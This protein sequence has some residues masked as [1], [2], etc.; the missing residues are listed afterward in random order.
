MSFEIPWSYGEDEIREKQEADAR[1]AEA[2]WQ[3]EE[4]ET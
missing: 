1:D 4:D 2:D 3:E